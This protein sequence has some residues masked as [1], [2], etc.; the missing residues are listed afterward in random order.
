MLP[1]A[2]PPSH[3]CSPSPPLLSAR[4]LAA[5]AAAAAPKELIQE[6][7]RLKGG[8]AA[9]KEALLLALCS[10][11]FQGGRTIVFAKTKQRAHRCG[12]G[13]A[14]LVLVLVR[15]SVCNAP[16]NAVRHFFCRGAVVAVLQL[17]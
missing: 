11:A 9:Q 2:H 17:K 13:C 3:V 1:P 16:C 10:R 12:L 5:D 6:I 14:V 4:R 8:A 7:V 15:C